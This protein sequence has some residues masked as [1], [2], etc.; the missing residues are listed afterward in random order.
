MNNIINFINKI[1]IFPIYKNI[2]NLY[3]DKDF[4]ILD[5]I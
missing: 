4:K 2:Y 3:K 5:I 1:H